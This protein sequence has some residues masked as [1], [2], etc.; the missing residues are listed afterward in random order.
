M[1]EHSA[2]D[3]EDVLQGSA[4]QRT[5]GWY[6]RLGWWHYGPVIHI[7][8]GVCFYAR[9]TGNVRALFTL[10]GQMHYTALLVIPLGSRHHLGHGAHE[11]FVCDGYRVDIKHKF[12]RW[13]VDLRVAASQCTQGSLWTHGLYVRAT[14]TWQAKGDRL[15]ER[16]WGSST[17]CTLRKKKVFLWGLYQAIHLES[18]SNIPTHLSASSSTK[19]SEGGGLHCLVWIFRMS[20]LACHTK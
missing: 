18:L 8:R 16:C 1:G 17:S 11:V 2:D 14:I 4:Q 7:Q 20:L 5:D 6:Q 12:L 19:A 9:R 13:R 15:F 3:V 10:T